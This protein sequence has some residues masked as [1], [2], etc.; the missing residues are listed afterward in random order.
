MKYQDLF[1][2]VQ[3][4]FHCQVNIELEKVGSFAEFKTANDLYLDSDNLNEWISDIANKDG[5]EYEPTIWHET[6]KENKQEIHD[7]LE[8]VNDLLALL[9]GKMSQKYTDN[10]NN[11]TYHDNCFV[12]ECELCEFDS[13]SND[14][15]LKSLVS[16]YRNSR[17]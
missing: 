15:D 12:A 16:D 1:S 17:F 8:L 2:N 13:D 11:H 4:H 5:I 7:T 9:V 6:Q 10:Y 14:S 3:N